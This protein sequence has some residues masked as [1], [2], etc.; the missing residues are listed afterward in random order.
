[1]SY[2]VAIDIGNTTVSI[3]VCKGENKWRVISVPSKMDHNGGYYYR[4]IKKTGLKGDIK[5]FIISSVVP[6]LTV[7]LKRAAERFS[8]RVII[9][10]WRLSTGL[11]FEIPNP[12]RTGT[13]RIAGAVAAY[14]E[15]RAPLMVADFGT[16]T[17]LTVVGRG[18]SYLGGA[19][20]PGVET[21][22]SALS[23]KTSLLKRVKIKMPTSSIG[24][25][26][27][28]AIISGIIY[29]TAGAVERLKKEFENEIGYSLL[30]ILTGGYA[31]LMKHYL[32]DVHAIRPYL[33][34]DGLRLIFE[35]NMNE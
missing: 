27:S 31:G 4:I 22:N 19:I 17:T 25:N 35:R 1:M 33:V 26:T 9:M 2:I 21:M 32:S 29:G 6:E 18:G 14:N 15:F 13:D 23:E 30:L 12:R 16:A 10:D 34:L 3:G 24:S 7:R 20:I 8:K 11:R 5:G 28:M